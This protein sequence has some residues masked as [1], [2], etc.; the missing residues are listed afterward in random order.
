VLA[1][2]VFLATWR[3]AADT[4]WPERVGDVEA[5][6]ARA[7]ALGFARGRRRARQPEGKT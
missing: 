7:M 5:L 2:T 3:E 1:R 6:C 4:Q